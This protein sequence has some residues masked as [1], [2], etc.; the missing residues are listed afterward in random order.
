[1]HY[2]KCGEFRIQNINTVL[3]T[4]LAFL[5]IYCCILG[6]NKYFFIIEKRFCYDTIFH[7]SN[8]FLTEKLDV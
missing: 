5:P 8:M 2:I 4:I 3:I 1:M 6:E 7:E